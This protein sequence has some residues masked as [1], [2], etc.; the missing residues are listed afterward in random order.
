MLRA[1]RHALLSSQNPVARP[2]KNPAPVAVV[3]IFTGL[4][5]GIRKISDWNCIKKLLLVK[6]PSTFRVLKLIFVLLLIESMTALVEK[7][8]DSNPALIILSELEAK[9]TPSILAFIFEFQN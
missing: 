8:T 1:L 7:A 4:F 2:A 5:T 9:F 6:P 3:S